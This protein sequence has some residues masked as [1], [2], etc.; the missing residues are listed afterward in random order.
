MRIA[1]MTNEV[2]EVGVD[3]LYYCIITLNHLRAMNQTHLLL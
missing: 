2:D 1:E 3:V